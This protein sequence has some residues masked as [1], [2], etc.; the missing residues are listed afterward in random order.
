[1]GDTPAGGTPAGGAPTR[2]AKPAGKGLG[3]RRQREKTQAGR[4]VTG[5]PK[6][7]RQR[8]AVQAAQRQRQARGLV[9]RMRVPMPTGGQLLVSVGSV[10][11]FGGGTDWAP[12]QMAVVN[13]ANCE[14]LGGEGVDGQITN[15]GGQALAADRRA[16]PDEPTQTPA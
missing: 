8:E 1:M 7:K 15:A 14:G 13:A 4:P 16:L 3:P 11:D 9:E 12:G 10:L 5:E 6:T 2:R